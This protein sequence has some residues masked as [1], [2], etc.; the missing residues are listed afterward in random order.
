MISMR[1]HARNR[2]L[3]GLLAENPL[4]AAVAAIGFSV[5][6]QTVAALAKAH[7]LPG[8]APLYPVGIDIGI[9]ALV[10]ESRHCIEMHRSDF[11]PRALAWFLSA[12]TV[13]VNAH[14]AAPHDW[15]GRG[16]HVV[17][18][19]LWVVF[20]ELTRHRLISTEA[21]DAIPFGR[22]LA[23]WWT[24]LRMWQR[25]RRDGVT[26]YA[27]AV[28]LED[29]RVLMRDYVRA[30][31][32]GYKPGRSS[33]LGRRIRS[34][35]MPADVRAA[36]ADAV[37]A[38]QNTGWEQ[39]VLDSVTKA[40][41]M[42]AGLASSLENSRRPQA[43]P[44][45]DI[46]SPDASGAKP[47]AT[48]RARPAARPKPASGPALKL[49]PARS[50]SMTPEQLAENVAAMLDTYG[51]KAVSQARVKRDLSLGTEKAAEAIRIATRDRSALH[52]V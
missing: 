20:L 24:T 19:C 22:W 10:V 8:Y 30:A 29:A 35:R 5:S 1:S 38:G 41:V 52:A 32:D 49:S 21:S 42:P 47:D 51:D 34:G 28:A 40:L 33:L 17:M 37:A 39:A 18:P 4:L 7:G 50:R 16:L 48:L 43:S 26:S 9:L 6:F 11:I 13:Y 14:G 44:V 36:V 3:A 25:M 23:A 31:P 15:I 46:A 45:P 12:F 27:L 2:G